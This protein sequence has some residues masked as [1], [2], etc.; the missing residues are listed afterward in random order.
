MT[1]PI[2]LLDVDGVLNAVGRKPPK[3]AGHWQSWEQTRCN[4]FDLT[5]SLELLERIKALVDQGRVE[6]HWLTTWWND[7]ALLP[8]PH[9]HDY[10]VANDREEFLAGV[11][12]WKLP[13]AQRLHV[14]GRKMVW[15]DDDLAF[16]PAA[17]RWV[18]DQPEVLGIAPKTIH[19][20]TPKHLDAIEHFLRE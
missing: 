18:H 3:M 19:G 4:G 20:L 12:W 1:T 14:P 7:I 2:W 16:V 13:V 11:E 17:Q 5:F 6:V 10:P 15:T 8:F 9:F